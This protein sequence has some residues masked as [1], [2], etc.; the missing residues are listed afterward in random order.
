LGG[1]DPF[2]VL[3]D[4]DL[5][6]T[7]TQAAHASLLNTGQNCIAAELAEKFTKLLFKASKKKYYYDNDDQVPISTLFLRFHDTWSYLFQVL[8]QIRLAVA[9][10]GQRIITGFSSSGQGS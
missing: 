8:I 4:A 9:R 2:I 10:P 3:E 1:R 6:L 5:N 7:V